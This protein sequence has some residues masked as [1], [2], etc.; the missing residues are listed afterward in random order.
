MTVPPDLPFVP[1]LKSAHSCR[2]CGFWLEGEW[3]A[4]DDA[5]RDQI[6]RQM[7]VGRCDNCTRA[8]AADLVADAAKSAGLRSVGQGPGVRFGR[9]GQCRREMSGTRC[10]VAIRVID[11]RTLVRL[12]YHK[13]FPEMADNC[14][15]CNTPVGSVHHRWC[16]QDR[17]PVPDCN[18]QAAFCAH[19][20]QGWPTEGG[21]RATRRRPAPR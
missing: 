5:G 20:E 12:P 8:V 9:C 3:S 17:C 19:Q 18:S 4:A 14:N 15:D 11:G 6:S 2:R 7:A 16:D 21:R 13:H 1:P 10:A